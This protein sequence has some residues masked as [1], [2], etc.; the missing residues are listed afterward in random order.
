MSKRDYYEILG[1]TKNASES[2]IKSAFRRLARQ[3]HPDV[4]QEENA[5][6]KFKEINE[7]YGVLSDPQKR[8]KYDRFG[9]AGVG[10]MGGMNYDFTGDFADLFEGL[11]GGTFGFGSMGG[12]RMRNAPRRGRDLQKEIKL[13]FEEAVFGVEKEIEFVR[14]EICSTCNGSGANPGS[15]V[16]TC[17]TCQGLGEVRQVRQ[18]ILGQ[19]MQTVTC[20]KCNGRGQIIETLCHTCRGKGLE[21][22]T[23]KKKISIP[24]GV[25]KGTQIRLSGEG[26]P[27]ANGGPRGNLYLIINVKAHKFFQRRDDDILLN[28]D[29]NIAQAALGADIEIPTVDGKEILSI[30]AGT[31]SGKIFTMRSRGVPHLRRSGRGDQKIIVNVTVPKHLTEEQR[32]LF[33]DLAKTLNTEVKPR[34]RGFLDK[35]NEWLGG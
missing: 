13:T 9:H 21:R 26:Q 32:K 7:A 28:L 35:L 8:A 27:G 2:E 30:P 12:R 29:I 17:A 20:P 18:T 16:H 31:Q 5:E 15:D 23:I 11:F 6:E 3:Y 10:D 1:I 4:S 24:A 14:D 19:M 33:E 25:E 22:K 34:E